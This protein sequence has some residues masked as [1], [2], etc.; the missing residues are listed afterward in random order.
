MTQ[1][2]PTAYEADISSLGY[3]YAVSALPAVSRKLAV[4]EIEQAIVSWR[5]KYGEH[6]PA[7][8]KTLLHLENQITKERDL[9]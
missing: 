9:L 5:K 4:I 2:H 1:G 6:F 7:L 3:P 8:H